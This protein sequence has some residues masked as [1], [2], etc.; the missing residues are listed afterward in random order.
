MTLSDLGYTETQEKFRAEQNLTSFEVGRVVAEHKERYIVK[1]DKVELDAE[2]I[3]SLRYSAENRYD[4]PAVGDWVAF[5]EYDDNKAL[6]HAIFPR[7]SIIKRRAVGKHGQI[8]IIATNV[9]YGLLVQ[10]IDRDFNLNRL[11]RYLTICYDSKVAPIIVL[12]KTDLKSEAELAIILSQIKERI[13]DVPLFAISNINEEY[14]VLDA[15]IHHGKTYCLLGSSGVGKSTLLNNLSGKEL[16][17]TGSI[18]ESVNKGRHITSHRELILLDNGGIIIDNP[19][20]REVGITDTIMG[21][22]TTFDQIHHYAQSC[23]YADCTHLQEAGCAVLEALENE[24]IDQDAYSNY[25]KMQKEQA[26]F[27][28]DAIARKKKDKDLGKLIKN[29]KKQ[30]KKDKF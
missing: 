8:Q 22:E 15:E 14:K 5:T 16:M 27:E 9:D 29:Y 10:A 24:K 4:F 18:S 30:R 1:S 20:M 13:T 3:G 19:G 7:H 12:T 25:Q 26:H 28:S 11:E 2:L 21:L 17:K 23:K 6:I